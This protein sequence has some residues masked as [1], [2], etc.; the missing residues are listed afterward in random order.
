MIFKEKI[1]KK[2]L[3]FIAFEIILTAILAAVVFLTHSFGCAKN[4]SEDVGIFVNTQL[5]EFLKNAPPYVYSEGK[6]YTF[7]EY[8][9]LDN[10]EN[11]QLT[12]LFSVTYN[13]SPVRYI[14]IKAYFSQTC[15]DNTLNKIC[16]KHLIKV[17]SY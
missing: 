17:E 12:R 5:K 13:Q 14:C 8:Y 6:D 10:I 7:R 15:K 1:M 4:D 2:F 11:G 3:K 9:E 16:K